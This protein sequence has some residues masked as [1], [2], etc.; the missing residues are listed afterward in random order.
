[1]KLLSDAALKAGADT[2]FSA[3]E[4]AE[5]QTE[6]AKAGLS[7]EQIMGGALAGT[8]SWRRLAV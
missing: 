1:M 7:V 5:A 8:L 2:T 4:A 6:L 3:Q